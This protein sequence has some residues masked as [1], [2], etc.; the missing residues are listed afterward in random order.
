MQSHG[1]HGTEAKIDHKIMPGLKLAGLP[2]ISVLSRNSIFSIFTSN[3]ISLL[4][5]VPNVDGNKLKPWHSYLQIH[6]R[7]RANSNKLKQIEKRNT[8]VIEKTNT[9]FP[10]ISWRRVANSLVAVTQVVWLVAT[11]HFAA[12]LL[13]AIWR[14]VGWCLGAEGGWFR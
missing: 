6:G 1:A 4:S 9:D 8:Q 11:G 5:S 10:E 14:W 2:I 3:F 7:G 13:L 12:G